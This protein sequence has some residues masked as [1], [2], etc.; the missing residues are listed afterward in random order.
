MED[1]V[2]STGPPGKTPGCPLLDLP[3]ELDYTDCEAAGASLSCFCGLSEELLQAASF[4]PSFCLL[5]CPSLCR[6]AITSRVPLTFLSLLYLCV[7]LLLLP[8]ILWDRRKRGAPDFLIMGRFLLVYLMC[9]VKHL[10]GR[11]CRDE[12]YR[13]CIQ[14]GFLTGH[15]AHPLHHSCEAGAFTAIFMMRKT[16]IRVLP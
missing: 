13:P 8:K 1:E 3:G 5:G 7:S 4:M 15:I 11:G 6:G 2:L 14:V 16:E 12:G 10:G 9:K